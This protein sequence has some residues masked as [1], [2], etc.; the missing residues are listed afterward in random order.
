MS[1]PLAGIRVLELARILAGPW[2][3]QT[4]ADLGADVIKVESPEGDETRRWGPPFVRY[5][6]GGEDAAYFHSCNRGKRSVVADFRTE[7]GRRRVRDLC[8]G[9]DVVI[10]NFKRGD[11]ARHGLDADTLRAAHP[12]LVW[13]SITGLED[14]AQRGFHGCSWYG[15]W[16]RVDSPTGGGSPQK[17]EWLSPPSFTPIAV[18][19]SK[20]RADR[21]A[22]EWCGRLHQHVAGGTVPLANQSTELPGFRALARRMRN[23]S[24]LVPPD[25][26]CCRWRGGG[27][28]G[29]IPV[30]RPLSAGRA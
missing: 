13:C 2:A 7:A 21:R 26:R 11:L 22:P 28:V 15:A 4:L 25:L 17:P 23:A 9:A 19:P 8:A 24:D 18:S 6:D 29:S 20:P 5:A 16:R 12:H 10:E 3:G 14:R 1:A 27:R 30:P